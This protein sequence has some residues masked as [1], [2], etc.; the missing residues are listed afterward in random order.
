VGDAEQVM[1]AEVVDA[2]STLVEALLAFQADAPKLTKDATNPHFK[3]K[4]TSLDSLIA[5][6]V[7]VLS[8][9][10]LVWLTRPGRDET[11]APALHYELLYAPSGER[12]EGAMPLMLSKED[13]QGQGS[14]LTYARRY[15]M[16][17]VLGLAADDDD[18][19]N[20]ARPSK[21][22]ADPFG[23]PADGDLIER[24][25]RAIAYTLDPA[26]PDPK[27]DAVKRVMA[28]IYR[29]TGYYPQ[30]VL[31]ALGRIGREL[32]EAKKAKDAPASE[33]DVA[34]AE[35]LA[36]EHQHA[37]G[38]KPPPGSVA[39]PA[40]TGG[41]EERDIETL[42]NAGCCCPA[43]LSGDFNMDCP[44]KGQGIPVAGGDTNAI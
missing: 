3:N 31:L 26:N 27:G 32:L 44:L 28:A 16:V 33:A 24:I 1:D 22:T 34:R 38:E 13:P 7:P 41:S 35:K 14:A 25:E 4:Y 12:V 11:G 17:S 39:S 40:L 9:H 42:T 2:P 20:R 30:A 37:V 5:D 19:G 6:V 36:T 29:E 10:K 15:S 21:A 8:Q 23:P 43:P 18:D